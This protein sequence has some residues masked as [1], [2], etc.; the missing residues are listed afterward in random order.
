MSLARNTLKIVAAVSSLFL[1]SF[2]L[3]WQ[4]RDYVYLYLYD[5]SNENSAVNNKEGVEGVMS[6]MKS[7][8]IAELDLEYKKISKVSDP[9]FSGMH[10]GARFYIVDPKA[11]YKRI[12]GEVR[13]RDLL[14]RDEFYR[15]SIMDRSK[16]IYWRIDKKVL[17]KI[18]ELR[19]ELEKNGYAQDAFEVSNGYRTPEHNAAVGGASK[20]RHIKG[21]A[22]DMIIKDVNQDGRYTDADKQIVIDIL[23]RKVIKNEGGIGLYPG[24]R[25]VHMDIRGYRARWDSY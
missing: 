16:S 25:V 1:L 24:T 18:V 3:S 7:V 5:V 14:S 13:I 21:E 12:V 22:V 2:V 15:A 19:D 17:F 6:L 10:A 4:V 20:S 8:P 9:S 23:E 11:I